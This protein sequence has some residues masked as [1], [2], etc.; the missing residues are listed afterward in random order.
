MAPWNGTKGYLLERLS[1]QFVEFQRHWMT[2]YSESGAGATRV[3]F[4]VLIIINSQTM[5]NYEHENCNSRSGNSLDPLCFCT[6]KLF[7]TPSSTCSRGATCSNPSHNSWSSESKAIG[8]WI[9]KRREEGMQSI[10]FYSLRQSPAGS[11]YSLL[12]GGDVDI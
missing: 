5:Q 7:R 10:K 4:R 11:V 6:N 1:A 12:A 3:N 9:Q 8:S 2:A